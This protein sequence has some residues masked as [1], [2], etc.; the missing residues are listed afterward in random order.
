MERLLVC[1]RHATVTKFE[2][3]PLRPL[4]PVSLACPRCLAER[5]D[6]NIGVGTESRMGVVGVNVNGTDEAKLGV[7][8]AKAYDDWKRRQREDGKPI[9]GSAEEAEALA[10]IDEQ[11][12]ATA[13]SSTRDARCASPSGAT[14]S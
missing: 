2:T 12:V 1:Y 3:E 11:R 13:P 7:S 9:P 14:S 4:P 5:N 10:Q 8:G 6:S